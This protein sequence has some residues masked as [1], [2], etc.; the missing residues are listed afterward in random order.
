MAHQDAISEDTHNHSSCL[1]E[2]LPRFLELY[3]ASSPSSAP[4][5]LRT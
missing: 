3:L 1:R 2:L 4:A 5:V